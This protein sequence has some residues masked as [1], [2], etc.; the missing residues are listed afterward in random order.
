MGIDV[1]RDD[2]SSSEVRSLIAE[3]LSGMHNSSPPGHVHA[4]AIENLRAPSV[5]LWTAWVDGVLCGCGALKELDP[6]TGEVKS[7]RTRAAF[8]RRG[9]AQAILDEI[10]R[11]ARQRGYSR[12]LLE[13]GTGQAFEPAHALYRRNGFEWSGA[14]GEYAATNFNV[15]MA[16]VLAQAPQGSAMELVRPE[17]RHLASYVTALNRGWSADNVRGAAAAEEELKRIESDPD[18]FLASLEDREARGPMIKLPDGSEVKRIPGFRRWMWDTEFC[19]SIGLRWQPGTTALPPHCLGHIGYAVVPWKQRQ[20]IGTRA[21]GFLLPEAWAV[22]L[23]FVEITTDGENIASQRVI[24]AN[25]GVL[26]EAFI[27]PAQFGPKPGL[28]YRI[29]Q[30]G[31]A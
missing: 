4:L 2:L 15:F 8:L 24:E 6:C 21:L 1:R 19:G 10:V 26:I 16:K 3:H 18:A 23:P 28:R 5:T 13:T 12:L 29:Y 31:G 22:G 20:R 25:G 7:M 17:R 14:F 9:I 11:T 27:K 30:R